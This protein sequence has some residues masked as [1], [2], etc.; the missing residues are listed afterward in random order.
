MDDLTDANAF[1]VHELVHRAVEGLGVEGPR[2]RQSVAKTAEPG[3][4]TVLPQP[5]IERLLIVRDHIV[6]L[7]ELGIAENVTGDLD[8]VAG[9]LDDPTC[10]SL[11]VLG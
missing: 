9:R 5:L 10:P 8:S 1:R 2:G 6:R 4:D 3:L 11:L 7:E